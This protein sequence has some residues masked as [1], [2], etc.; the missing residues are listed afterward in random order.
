MVCKAEGDLELLEVIASLANKSLLHQEERAGQPRFGMLETIREYALE[1]LE[2]SGEA[3]AI[4]REHAHYFLRLAEEAEPYLS[5]PQQVEWF[6]RLEEEYDNF[7][8]ALAWCRKQEEAEPGLRLAGALHWFWFMHGH[9]SEGR[10]W[11]EAM[12][13]VDDRRQTIEGEPSSEVLA[14]AVMGAGYLA[15]AQG[16]YPQAVALSQ[17]ALALSQAIGDERG[18]ALA[19]FVLGFASMGRGDFGQARMLIEAA[20]VWPR[21]TGD[22]LFVLWGLTNLGLIAERQGEYERAKALLEDGLAVAQRIG[23]KG[24]IAYAWLLLAILAQSEGDAERAT[25]WVQ[26]S[27]T[28][29]QQVGDRL[30]MVLGLNVLAWAMGRQGQPERVARLMGAGEAL[31]ETL[32]A[33][34]PLVY[35]ADHDRYVTAVRVQLDEATF[36]SAWA[37]GRAMPLE[38]AIDYALE[39]TSP[40]QHSILS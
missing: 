23:D 10:G 37:E 1:Q 40:D 30:L 9:L 25:P 31:E 28:L 15:V 19:R 21:K 12:L 8:A 22:Q 29:L 24:S 17:E 18:T 16:D 27:L 2:A 32:G 4:Q 3:E 35:R 5:G 39:K 26:D 14:K 11:L 33:P 7:R 13:T 36:Q 38:R 6:A 34:L 20:L